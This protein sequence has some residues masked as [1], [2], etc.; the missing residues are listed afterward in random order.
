[1]LS[2]WGSATTSFRLTSFFYITHA[3]FINVSSLGSPTWDSQ[4]PQQGCSSVGT[5]GESPE[6]PLWTY[7]QPCSFRPDQ[8]QHHQGGLWDWND[9]YFYFFEI[10]CLFFFYWLVRMIMIFVDFCRCSLISCSWRMCLLV[11]TEPWRELKTC[12]EILLEYTLVETLCFTHSFRCTILLQTCFFGIFEI[13]VFCSPTQCDHGT[14]CA[15]EVRTSYTTV[16]DESTGLY[17]TQYIHTC[18]ALWFA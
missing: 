8:P 12:S 7:W 10:L 4:V 11:Q 9:F 18:V 14:I 17:T 6:V 15:S 2:W 3:I 16:S 13:F 5:E 1:M